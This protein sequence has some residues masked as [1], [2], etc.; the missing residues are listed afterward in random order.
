MSVRAVLLAT[1]MLLTGLPCQA[2][3]EAPAPGQ[4][5][6]AFLEQA[7]AERHLPGL[8]VA[9]VVDGKV[10]HR[11]GYGRA[12]LEWN[13][14]ATPTTR[15]NLASAGKAFTA[16]LVLG[17][18]QDGKLALDDAVGKHLPGL[19][20]HWQAVTVRQ[21]LSH[22]SGI[23]SFTDGIETRCPM[24]KA[25][26]LYERGD[27]LGE[28]ACR[29]LGFVPG[30]DWEYAETNFYLLG[31]L[32]ERITGGSYERALG[33]RL[34][35]PLG[36]QDTTVV[37]Y[38]RV[39]PQR[40]AGYAVD[41]DG[42]RNAP[43]YEFDEFG[44]VSTLDDMVRFLPAFEADI[45]LSAPLRQEMQRNARLA[46]GTQVESYGLGL[47]VTPYRGH[48]RYGHNGGGGLGFSTSFTVFPDDKVAVV[49]LA[50]ADQPTGI[51]KLANEIAARFLPAGP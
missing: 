1:A 39:L 11:R 17:L 12:N 42:F 37:D 30:T 24:Q 20:A 21:L 10:V 48:R 5:L 8:A 25:P 34:A 41:G 23:P 33:E 27:V 35:R 28:V 14:P 2:R 32:V 40:A 6:D 47:G 16:L 3:T 46:D 22:T 43:R 26:A 45:V 4:S 7:M 15:F 44:L 13:A 36:L 9:V 38:A 18:V 19:P 29:P 50:N 31:M 51:G 49:V